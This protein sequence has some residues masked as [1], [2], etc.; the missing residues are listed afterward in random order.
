MF[1]LIC[2]GMLR[3]SRAQPVITTTNLGVFMRVLPRF[4]MQALPGMYPGHVP[5]NPIHS[6]YPGLGGAGVYEDAGR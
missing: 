2:E 3:V 4:S 6:P 5:P 1:S